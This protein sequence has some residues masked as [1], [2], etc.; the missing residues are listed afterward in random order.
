MNSKPRERHVSNKLPFLP[1]CIPDIGEEE[2]EEVVD[3]LRGRSHALARRR[4]S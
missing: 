3:T 4:T 1:F 2:I